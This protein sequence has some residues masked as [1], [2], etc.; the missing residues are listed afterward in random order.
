MPEHRVVIVGGGFGGLYAARR[1][2]RAPV[3]L[4]LIDRR[5]FHVFQP[6]LYQVAT[7][8]L[9]PADIASA[10]R[11]TLRKQENTTVWLAAVDGIDVGR[12]R[13]TMADGDV[14]YDTLV[15]ATGVTHDYFGND[16]WERHAPGL[17]TIE[18]ATE[19][20]RRVLLAFEAAERD[21][22]ASRRAAWLTF[23]V[24]G[25]GPT[26]VE[27]AGAVAELSRQTL[28]R[29]FRHIDTS[30]AKI[31]LVEGGERILS[32]FPSKLSA[33]ATRSLQR[34]GV[35]VRTSAFVT[36]VSGSS[37]TVRSDDVS[38]TID[39][40]T[41][42]WGAGVT[43]SPLGRV[44]A[45]ATG[46]AIDELGRVM[47]E[48]DLTVPGH[49]DIFV[50][51]DLAHFAHQTGAPLPGI[52][53]VAISQGRYVANTIWRRL[54]GEPIKLFHYFDKGQLATIGRAAAVADFGR[55]RF[56][57]YPAWLLWLFV[58]LMYLV[59]FENRVLVFVQWAWSYFTRN[60]GA[61]LI[62]HEADGRTGRRVVRGAGDRS[63]ESE[64]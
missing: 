52:A 15:L 13:V 12:K 47:V 57:G 60:R 5:N 17:K 1:L 19:I 45:D 48:P 37:V 38:E 43:G 50:I 44:L 59:E 58:H 7:G 42:L 21:R 26:G 56:S 2:R 62:A 9:S 11:W 31:L 54:R 22:D 25:A 16:Q 29:D 63:D 49:S 40:R 20:R 53:P 18:D 33:K 39:T 4:T 6:L 3:D 27:L 55:L 61:R 8:G 35:T 34:L 51:G 46:V 24:V 28:R 36:D 32:S 64:R 23:V 14:P 10:L 30:G 41:V